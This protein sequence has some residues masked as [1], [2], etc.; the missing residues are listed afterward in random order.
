MA[1]GVS[2]YH[3]GEGVSHYHFGGGSMTSLLATPE[4]PYLN[5]V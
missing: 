3:F 5:N 1:L 4:I 2:H